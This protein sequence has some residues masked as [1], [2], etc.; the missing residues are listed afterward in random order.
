MNTPSTWQQLRSAWHQAWGQRSPRE[1]GLL[2][3][4]APVFVLA[5]LWGLALAPAL[6][7]WQ[8]APAQQARLDTQ[9]QTMQR[10]QAQA[11]SLQKSTLIS[12]NESVQWLEKSTSEL[13]AG[14]KISVQG[15]RATLSLDAA[16][17][18]AVARWLSLARERALALPIQAQL[19]HSRDA[20]AALPKGKSKTD[21]NTAI[22][23]I[24][25]NTAQ[26]AVLL[27]GTV[28]LR[29]P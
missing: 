2:G 19:Q 11:K 28:V 3:V 26:N 5:G 25:P 7:T 17:A 13:G 8:E 18:E 21:N 27:R 9:T 15:D 16:P 22:N 23:T 10:L 29:L 24:T 20:A 6:R 4:G 1:K 14:A 12:R